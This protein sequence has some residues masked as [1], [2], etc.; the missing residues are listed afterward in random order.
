MSTDQEYEEWRQGRREYWFGVYESQAREAADKVV[1]AEKQLAEE[2]LLLVGSGQYHTW[3]AQKMAEVK[4][5]A[6]VTLARTEHEIAL[7]RLKLA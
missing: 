6:A 3:Q 5:G 4:F 7:A 1:A 2:Y